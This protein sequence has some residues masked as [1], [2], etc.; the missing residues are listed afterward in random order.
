MSM[1]TLVSLS[2][3]MALKNQMDVIANNI[4]NMSTPGFQGERPLFSQYLARS[5]GASVSFVQDGGILRDTRPGPLAHT[6]NNL[7]LGINGEGYFVVESEGE[8]LYTRN[9]SFRLD[10]SGRLTTATGDLVMSDSNQPIVFAP[11]EVDIQIGRD[12]TVSTEN[13]AVGRIRLVTFADQ[14]KLQKAGD[15]LLKT[16]EA[17]I[18]AAN[19]EIAQGMLEGSNVQ[20]VIE[21]TRMIDVLRSFQ[22]AA[23]M[24][25]SDS[26]LGSR[27]IKTL[28]EIV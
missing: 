8:R 20:S 22:K 4:A 21:M 16:D 12:G 17:P 18:E 3:Q 28:T 5:G 1:S 26:E 2:H 27:A 6:G 14:Q 10:G 15:T 11:D 19:A 7:D 13:G 24:I 25:D 23:K 9:G